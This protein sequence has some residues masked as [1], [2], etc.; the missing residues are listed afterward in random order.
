MRESMGFIAHPLQQA[1]RRAVARQAQRFRAAGK[2]DFLIFL[3]Q[4]NEGDVGRAN[5]ARCRD[6]GTQLAA[7]T[8]D[9][10]QIGYRQLFVDATLEV[11]ADD[12][13]HRSKVIIAPIAPD[14]EATVLALLRFGVDE[15]DRAA[16]DF[17]ALQVRI[18]KQTMTRGKT[19]NSRA[20]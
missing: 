20:S 14:T 11:A 8:V 18:V 10:G 12:F 1:Q 2:V 4:S 7:S 13:S 5:R 16:H 9:H 6:C 15:H 3:S 19:F 17:S